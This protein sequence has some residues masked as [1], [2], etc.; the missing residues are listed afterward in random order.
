[1]EWSYIWSD[2]LDPATLIP[3]V[4]FCFLPVLIVIVIFVKGIYGDKKRA[5]ILTKAAEYG[6]NVDLEKMAELLQSRGGRGGKD[7][8]EILNRRLMWGTI[9]SLVGLVLIVVPLILMSDYEFFVILGSVIAAVGG[10]LL[11]V[12]FATR[13]QIIEE[14]RRNEHRSTEDKK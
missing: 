8:I 14:W 3:L 2:L 12:Y 7:S 1:M 5:D 9:F 11:I 10:G 6:A 13:T 4:L